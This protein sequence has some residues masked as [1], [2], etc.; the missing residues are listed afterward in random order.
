MGIFS[1]TI[2]NNEIVDPISDGIE[3][4]YDIY[5]TYGLLISDLTI[6][7]NTITNP[8]GYGIEVSGST[9]TDTA[10][11]DMN[12]TIANNTITNAGYDGLNVE[13]SFSDYL[14]G[15][16]DLTLS[17]NTISGSTYEGIELSLTEFSS[18]TFDVSV[19]IRGNTISDSGTDGMELSVSSLS[20]ATTG[21]VDI[22]DNVIDNAA[23]KGLDLDFEDFPAPPSGVQIA[24]NTVINGAQDG[25]NLWNNYDSPP[26]DFG[27]GDLSSPGLNTFMNNTGY[28]FYNRELDPVAAHS[29]WWGT[30]DSGIIDSHIWDNE[31]DPSVGAVEFSGWLS[32]AP[33]VSATATLVDTL[34]I[35]LSP[36]GPSPTDTFRYTATLEG[37][38]DCGC[39]SAILTVPIPDNGVLS[40]AR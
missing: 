10:T 19:T 31:E 37:T 38:G 12:L 33:A 34:H 27:G 22:V 8:G 11:L 35:D 26:P 1:P 23:E 21:R 20:D 15:S 18:G 3:M 28:D 16:V 17:G 6:A 29:N 25:V 9:F 2:L 36:P 7:G 24:C 4:D 30:T 5:E 39:A 40:P 13:I 32:A 14:Y